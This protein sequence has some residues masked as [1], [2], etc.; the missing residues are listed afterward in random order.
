MPDGL[1]HTTI[2]EVVFGK[3]IGK[4]QV[5]SK[6][7]LSTWQS[8]LI[9]AV[10]LLTF[11]T[12]INEAS[13]ARGW[14]KFLSKLVGKKSKIFF[15]KWAL[16]VHLHSL[17]KHSALVMPFIIQPSRTSLGTVFVYCCHTENPPAAACKRHWLVYGLDASSK[18]E[19]EQDGSSH[20]ETVC[21]FVCMRGV[22]CR[23]RRGGSWLS[24]WAPGWLYCQSW[25]RGM[26][27]PVTLFN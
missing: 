12:S 21:L 4:G 20:C 24:Q 1:L 2:W 14:L 22:G 17:K 18:L 25:H 11:T 7:F 26:T 3:V 9:I 8:H 15:V 5:L 16:H 27:S 10:C 13:L 6:K 23:K 19:V